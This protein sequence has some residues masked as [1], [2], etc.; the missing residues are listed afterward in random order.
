MS[1]PQQLEWL[2]SVDDHVIEPPG[3]W[4]DRLPKKYRDVGPR[5]VEDDAGPTWVFEDQRIP[6]G[7]SVTNGAIPELDQRSLPWEMIGFD[8]IHPSCYDPVERTKAMDRDHI[9]ASLVFANL[10]GFCGNLFT[11][12]QDK[13]LALA[14]VKAWN[15][16]MLD[17]WCGSAPGRFIPNALI[18]MWDPAAAAKEIERVADKGARAFSYSQMPYKIGLPSIHDKDRFW[19]PVFQAAN[20][21]ELVVCTHLGSSSSFPETSPDAPSPVSQVLFQLAGQETLLDWLFSRNFQRFP[22]LKLALSENGI[23]WIP[24]VLQV[25]Q[26]MQTMAREQIPM[27]GDA[28]ND[29]IAPPSLDNDTNEVSGQAF[30]EVMKRARRELEVPDIRDQF[31]EHVFGCFIEDPHGIASIDEIGVDNVMIESDFPH[32]STLFPRTAEKAAHVLAPLSDEVRYKILQGNAKRVFR[33]E[34]AEIPALA[35]A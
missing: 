1:D 18:P 22:N 15:D 5:F 27:P 20:D 12:A 33:F 8:R 9:L 26:W 25:A 17:E 35:T 30:L 21:T 28:E 11:K 16:W 6:I 24:S 32:T 3:V 23:S 2:I 7:G 4:V 34:P 13:K 19:D 29:P 14:C 10:P 31:R